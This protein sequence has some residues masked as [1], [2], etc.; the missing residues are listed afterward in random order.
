[1]K[2]ILRAFFFCLLWALFALLIVSWLFD[3]RTDPAPEKQIVLCADGCPADTAAL[4]KRLLGEIPAGIDYVR[5]HMLAWSFFDTETGL[6]LA[7]L[8]ILPESE[9]AEFADILIPVCPVYDAGT[10]TGVLAGYFAFAEGGGA[11]QSYTLYYRDRGL[12]EAHA[13]AVLALAE[14]LPAL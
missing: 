12:G 8:Y 5:V 11:G 2:K 10:G 13:Q 6:P 4:E 9:A 3:L 14:A 7:D 1:M